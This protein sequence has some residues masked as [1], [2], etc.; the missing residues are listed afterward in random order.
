MFWQKSAYS[1][2]LLDDC[3]FGFKKWSMKYR[4][5]ILFPLESSGLVSFFLSFFLSFSFFF[6]F[7][8]SF[9]SFFFLLLIIYVFI[10]ALLFVITFVFMSFS[11]SDCLFVF[12]SLFLFFSQN[13]L[14]LANYV[15]RKPDKGNLIFLLAILAE[16]EGENKT[17]NQGQL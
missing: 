13:T 14:K 2:T 1:F 8:R 10:L 16:V 4:I 5:L 7:F 3:M 12:L 15:W 6:S 11:W 9:R 17:W